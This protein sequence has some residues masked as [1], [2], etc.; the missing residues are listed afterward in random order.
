MSIL[1]MPSPNTTV[2]TLTGK[3]QSM[4]RLSNIDGRKH[5]RLFLFDSSSFSSFSH[6]AI[7]VKYTTHTN[8]KNAT[9]TMPIY[10]Y[11]MGW[12]TKLLGRS[13]GI[14][15]KADNT[16]TMIIGAPNHTL[17]KIN[18]RNTRLLSLRNCGNSLHIPS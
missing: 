16:F 18:V 8:S 13:C 11:N 1:P 12:N 15:C 4:I 5:F 10:A 3:T 9:T 17:I 7:I 6:F 2:S 14:V